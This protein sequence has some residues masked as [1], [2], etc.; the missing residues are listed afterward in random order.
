MDKG[1]RRVVEV[2]PILPYRGG[3]RE[4]R[5]G[6]LCKRENMEMERIGWVSIKLGAE[7]RFGV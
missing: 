5:Y 3:L 1:Q 7:A 2:W 6:G 4:M